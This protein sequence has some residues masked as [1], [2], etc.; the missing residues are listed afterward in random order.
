V[1]RGLAKRCSA[2]GRRYA[3]TSSLKWRQEQR[4]LAIQRLHPDHR[5]LCTYFVSRS[6]W[7]VQI[8]Y[9]SSWPI[10]WMWLDAFHDRR[11][12]P[13][14]GV[15]H[16]CLEPRFRPLRTVDRVPEVPAG[17]RDLGVL[18]RTSRADHVA[19]GHK[20]LFV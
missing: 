1:E 13:P 5:T 18:R 12:S 15:C 16:C 10:V 20:W 11:K 7:G 2:D 9:E 6:D 8:P 19:D 17:V 3:W 14:K 4:H